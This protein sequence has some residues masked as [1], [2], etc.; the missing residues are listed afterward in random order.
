MGVYGSVYGSGHGSVYG[1]SHICIN[2]Y[3]AYLVYTYMR[4]IWVY[5]GLYMG[6]YISLYMVCLIYV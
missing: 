5:M 3:E 1:M 4:H 2:I 6:L